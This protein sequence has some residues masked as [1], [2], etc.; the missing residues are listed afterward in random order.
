MFDIGDWIYGLFGDS[1]WG[2]ILCVFL[3]FLIDAVVFPA[4]PELF[5]VMGYMYPP[6]PNMIFGIE[7]LLAAV[8]AEVIGITALYWITEHIRIPAKIRNIAERYVKFLV[9]SDERILLVNR[10]APMIPFAGAFISI[11]ESWKLSKALFYVVIGCVLK[12]GI[13][14][15]M[16]S[17][18]FEYF[19]GD[20]AQMYTI[21]FIFA[22]IILSFIA[23]YVKK[24]RSGI[25]NEDS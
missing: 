10:V 13:I 23:A 3:V 9:V 11:M 5:F 1:A 7:L 20:E 16:S 12:Y 4:L 24:K 6:T 2:V 19:S 22:I 15:A 17:F 21:A 14:L 18:F 25:E 8:A